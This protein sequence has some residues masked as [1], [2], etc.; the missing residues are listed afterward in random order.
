MWSDGFATDCYGEE[1]VGGIQEQT[2]AGKSHE[3]FE[4]ERRAGCADVGKGVN[5]N[6]REVFQ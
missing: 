1:D 6:N 5:K 3:V 2:S 4:K